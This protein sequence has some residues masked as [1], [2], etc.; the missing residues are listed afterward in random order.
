M[1]TAR[2]ASLVF[3]LL[4]TAMTAL[5]QSIPSAPGLHVAGLGAIKRICVEKISGEEPLA[6]AARE[7]AIAGLFAAKR[8][9]VTERCDKADAVLK[10]AVLERNEKRVRAEGEAADFGVA[11]GA[12]S[13]T[14]TGGAAAIGALA[15]GSSESLLSA[16]SRTSASVILR[17]V[18]AE[19]I[20]LWAYSQDS[21]GG[22]VKGALA[23]AVDR[24]VKQLLREI[25]RST[26][27]RPVQ[28]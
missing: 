8:F 2:A 27:S 25:E 17:L 22:K 3:L 28:P 13:V 1:S 4:A 20:V 24:A 23:D 7:L 5:S 12:A 11:A 15:G 9:V 19:G 10:G 26:A 18:D 16:E 21:P 6:P 14:R